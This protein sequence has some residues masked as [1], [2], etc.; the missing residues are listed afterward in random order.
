MTQS[1]SEFLLPLHPVSFGG[2]Q[3]LSDYVFS[4]KLVSQWH[5]FYR[6]LKYDMGSVKFFWYLTRMGGD[7]CSLP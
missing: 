6:G 7:L 4:I 1:P 5:I 2:G 3:I